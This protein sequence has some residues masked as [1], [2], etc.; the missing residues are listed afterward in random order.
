MKLKLNFKDMPRWALVTALVVVFLTGMVALDPQLGIFAPRR[1]SEPEGFES[2][3]AKETE[4]ETRTNACPNLL[5]KRGKGLML[6]FADPDQPPIYFYDLDEYKN[7]V[8]MMKRRGNACPVLYVQEENNA[9]GQNVY[10][11][12]D[13]P[14]YIEGG[15]PPLPVAPAAPMNTPDDPVDTRATSRDSVDGRYNRN[16]Y[17]AFDPYGTYVGVYT[18][19]D[20]VHDATQ[21]LSGLN[22]LNPADPNWGGV[23]MTQ[24]AV[25]DGQFA[26][27]TVVKAIYPNLAP[28]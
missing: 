1:S 6:K 22:S 10:K 16:Q 23:M 14:F 20:A 21:T 13:S 28:K 9:Q 5:V 7:Y 24:Q 25:D 15:L 27:N 19:V 2:S 12:Y 11:M 3:G 8:E 17:P 4:D 18:D 26:E